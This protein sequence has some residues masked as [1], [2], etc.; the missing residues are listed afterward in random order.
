MPF[1][2]LAMF[3]PAS[4]L[5]SRMAIL[6]PFAASARAVAAPRPEAPPVMTAGMLWSS[7]MGTP[8]LRLS[9]AVAP[10]PATS[11]ASASQPPQAQRRIGKRQAPTAGVPS[12]ASRAGASAAAKAC[13]RRWPGRRVQIP[14]RG[15][16]GLGSEPRRGRESLAPIPTYQLATCARGAAALNPGPATGRC[17]HAPANP[18]AAGTRLLRNRRRT[19]LQG[20]QSR[21]SDALRARIWRQLHVYDRRQLRSLGSALGYLEGNPAFA[22]LQLAQCCRAGP[23]AGLPARGRGTTRSSHRSAEFPASA[24]RR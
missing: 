18:V 21:Q 8:L 19:H 7:C 22:A 14:A 24:A 15:C 16:F 23:A 6:T 4:A 13:P 11:I 3:W 12:S 1:N 9:I 17:S 20:H 2:S 5:R 10:A